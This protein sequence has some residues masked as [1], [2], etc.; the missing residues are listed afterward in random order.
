MFSYV[1][2]F[3]KVSLRIDETRNT[4]KTLNLYDMHAEDDL[5]DQSMSKGN[6]PPVSIVNVTLTTLKFLNLLSEMSPM[7]YYCKA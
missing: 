7:Q 4:R 6:S 1:D 2:Q 5:E 3:V